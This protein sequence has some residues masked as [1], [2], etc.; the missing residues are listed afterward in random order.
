MK[1]RNPFAVFILSIITLGIYDIYW[2]VVI[3]K[4]LNA[5]TKFHIPSIWLLI[6]PLIIF[7]AGIG[8][9]IA[10]S[11]ESSTQTNTSSNYSSGYISTYSYGSTTTTTKTNSAVLVGFGLY[12]LAFIL[13]IPISF[14]WFWRF[15][16]AVNEYTNGKSSTGLTFILLWLLHFIGVALVQDSFNDTLD[17]GG[18]APAATATAGQTP[19][20]AVTPVETPRPMDTDA[21]TQPPVDQPQ[22]GQEQPQPSQEPTAAAEEPQTNQE[23]T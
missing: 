6:V 3:R 9:V 10:G 2:L 1:K 23:Q 22:P 13:A 8:T 19:A 20:P 14:Y 21:P 16:K 17:A 11:L 15:S 18:A 5:K 12:I 4:E 7:L